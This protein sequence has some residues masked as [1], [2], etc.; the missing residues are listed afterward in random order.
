MSCKPIKMA[1]GTFVLANVKTG[2]KLNAGDR[3]VIAEWVQ[4]CRDRRE[5]EQRK[6]ERAAA[7]AQK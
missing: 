3:A 4:F 7:R 1:D 2:E 5:K 6:K